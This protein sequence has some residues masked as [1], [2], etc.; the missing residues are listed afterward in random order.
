M[1]TKSWSTPQPQLKK[2]HQNTTCSKKYHFRLVKYRKSLFDAKKKYPFFSSIGWVEGKSWET[3]ERKTP[4]AYSAWHM[5]DVLPT[6]PSAKLSKSKLLWLSH[7]QCKQ[8]MHTQIPQGHGPWTI[9]SICTR[10][11]LQGYVY[12]VNWICTVKL[13]M[14][15][16]RPHERWITLIRCLPLLRPFFSSSSSISVKMKPYPRTNPLSKWQLYYK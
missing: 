16:H 9:K 7:Q 2:I 5:C 8:R 12:A 1:V 6:I 14:K 4:E 15:V 11:I 3:G 10:Q 13:I